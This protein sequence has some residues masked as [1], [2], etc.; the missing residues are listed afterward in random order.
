ML[1]LLTKCVTWPWNRLCWLTFLTLK[2][3]IAATT[4]FFQKNKVKLWVAAKFVQKLMIMHH[5]ADTIYFV[6][7]NCIPLKFHI[8]SN[9]HALRTLAHAFIN[10][11][12]L[13]LTHPDQLTNLSLK[14]SILQNWANI[15][16]Y[17]ENITLKS[18]SLNKPWE[19]LWTQ[20]KYFVAMM[21][22]KNIIKI[23]NRY[24]R[25]AH[26]FRLCSVWKKW[27]NIPY[28]SS[29]AQF[30]TLSHVI[31]IVFMWN[32]NYDIVQFAFQTLNLKLGFQKVP[33]TGFWEMQIKR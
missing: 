10:K 31:S 4:I 11:H 25:L 32:N 21:I 23:N 6:Y 22:L 28:I 18:D 2:H 29:A 12:V 15:T 5:P 16:Q 8:R 20:N 30:Q 9:L 7:K 3:L 26:N 1:L 27:R 17:W 33:T 14:A 19:N 13:P 24:Q